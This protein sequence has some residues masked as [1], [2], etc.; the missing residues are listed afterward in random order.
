MH[1]ILFRI[2]LPDYN[3]PLVWIPLIIAILAAMVAVAKMVG[4]E[5]DRQGAAIAAVVA[6]A[7]VLARYVFMRGYS[8]TWNVGHIPIYATA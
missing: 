4:K 2:P 5:K 1:P 3:L 8:E 6:V 7:G